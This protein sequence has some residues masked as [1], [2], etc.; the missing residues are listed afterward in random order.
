VRGDSADGP[1]EQPEGDESF[2]PEVRFLLHFTRAGHDAGYAT[3]E[4]EERVLALAGA[5]GIDGAQVSVTPTIAEVSLGPLSRQR[6]YTL[7][8]HPAALDLGTIARL[9]DLVQAVLDGSL[10]AGP[11]LT[12]VDEIRARPLERPWPVVVGA[13][14]LAGMA[15]TPVIGGGWRE[16]LAAGLVGLIVG[17]V[18]IAAT[19]VPRME[20]IAPLLAAIVAS[21]C[22]TTLARLGVKE[23]PDVVALAALVSFLPGMTLTAGVR[24]LSTEQLQSGVAN[25]A[26]ALVQLL[27]LVVGYEVGT[28]IAVSWFGP[29]HETAPHVPLGTT[30]ILAAAAAG[31]AFT[32]SLRARTRDALVMCS[33][34]VLALVSNRA[35][36]ALLG[37]QAGV[38]GAAFAVGAAGGLVGFLLRRSPLVFLVPGVLM[39]VPGSAGFRS[40]LHLLT[41]RTVSGVTAGIEMFVTAILIAYGLMIATAV[42][43]QR[44]TNVT[45]RRP[46]APA[47]RR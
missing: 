30:Q 5:L 15:L 43:P 24:E 23:S 13:Y 22:A 8:V 32:V 17:G 6:T 34:T 25:T 40:V 39:L 41:D 19:R 20:P 4:L 38:F 46:V 44:F 2:T 10:G 27:G 26:K 12:R 31:L 29:V 21:F 3:A 35:G 7:R 1:A 37:H 9:D 18:A 33:A 47:A 14:G 11:A 28:S 45:G 42:L 36:S 16:A